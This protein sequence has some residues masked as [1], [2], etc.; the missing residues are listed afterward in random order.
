MITSL[1]HLYFV[2]FFLNQNRCLAFEDFGFIGTTINAGSVREALE[3]LNKREH[4]K[5]HLSLI[6]SDIGLPDGSGLDLIRE[7]KTNPF[8]V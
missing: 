1:L 6:I 3:L 8:C 5:Q 7:V 2:I 4:K